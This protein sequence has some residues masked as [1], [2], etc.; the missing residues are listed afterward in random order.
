MSHFLARLIERTRGTAPRVEPLITPRFAVGPITE[1][2]SEVDAPAVPIATEM[3]AAHVPQTTDSPVVRERSD[4]ATSEQATPPEEIK[5]DPE[6]LL[7]PPPAPQKAQES[8]LLVRQIV[9]KENALPPS[10]NG[11]SAEDLANRSPS[12]RPR[13]AITAASRDVPRKQDGVRRTD[14]F[15]RPPTRD[16][17]APGERTDQRPIVRVTI[18]RIEVRAA[19]PPSNPA[20]PASRLEPKLNLDTYLKERKGVRR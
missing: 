6:Q 10:L 13:S 19:A 1:I 8:V 14:E 16:V 15:P 18:G 20:K 3:A 5:R 4:L 9:S 11:A 17:F 2:A 12:K 7:V